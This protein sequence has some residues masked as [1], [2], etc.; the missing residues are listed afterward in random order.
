MRA[1]ISASP[2][3]TMDSALRLGD[4]ALAQGVVLSELC[5]QLVELTAQPLAS[6]L[7]A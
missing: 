4:P 3:P 2:M 1:L 7:R 6:L 5:F